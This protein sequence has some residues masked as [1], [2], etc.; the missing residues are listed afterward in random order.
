MNTYT[1]TEIDL[2]AILNQFNWQVDES[3]TNLEEKLLRELQSLEAV[4]EIFDKM[5]VGKCAVYHIKRRQ[6]RQS[7]SGN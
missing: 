5:I 2:E 1:V 6:G 4:Y 7:C 3:A